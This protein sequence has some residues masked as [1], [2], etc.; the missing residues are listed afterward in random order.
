MLIGETMATENIKIGVEIVSNT[1]NETAAAK[2]LEAA[3]KSAAKAA[4]SVGGTAG[5]RAMA[6]KAGTGEGTAYG[7][8]RS[9]VGTGA[10]GRDFAK[11]AQGLGGLVHVYATFAANLFAV[12][13]AFTALRNAADTTNMVNGLDQLGAVSGRS[14]GTLSKRVVD[15]T[16]GMV[17]LR[18]A[19]TATAQA[20]SAGMSSANL[21]KLAE[22]AKNA[23]AV[24]GISMPDALSRLSRGITK[25]EPELLDELGV[26]VKVDK[27]TT[28]YARTLGKTVGSLTDFEKRT[29]FAVAV[30]AELDTK[31]GDIEGKTN[32]F[33]RLQASLENITQKGLEVVAKFITPLVDLLA[34]SPTALATALTAVGVALLKMAIP[35]LSNWKSNLLAQA[36]VASKIA[37]QMSTS[38]AEYQ[39]E[40]TIKHE[41]EIDKRMSVERNAMTK[42]LAAMQQG[43]SG[44]VKSGKLFNLIQGGVDTVEK[45]AQA[46]KL[47]DTQIASAT[48]RSAKLANT[49]AAESASYANKATALKATRDQLDAYIISLNNAKNTK[50]KLIEAE[51]K[52]DLGNIIRRR[53]LEKA[54]TEYRKLTLLGSVSQDTEHMGFMG[55]ITKLREGVAGKV[56]ENFIGP[57]PRALEGWAKWSTLVQGGISA[58]VT[59][60]GSFLSAFSNIT[61]YIGIAIGAYTMFDTWLSKANKE[62]DDFSNSIDRNKEVTEGLGRTIEALYKNK[63]MSIE[64]I[65]AVSNAY[66]DLADS[67]GASVEKAKQFSIKQGTWDTIKEGVKSLFKAD[68]GSNLAESISTQVGYAFNTAINSPEK[69]KFQESITELLGEVKSGSD[70]V[71]KIGSNQEKAKQLLEIFKQYSHEIANSASRMNEFTSSLEQAVKISKDLSNSFI[72]SD[73]I[74]KLGIQML[75]VAG[76]MQASMDK[77]LEQFKEL[78]AVVKDT[79]KIAL[80]GPEVGA[81]LIQ[82]SSGVEQLASKLANTDANILFYQNEMAKIS[83]LEYARDAKKRAKKDE[84]GAAVQHLQGVSAEQQDESKKYTAIF[85]KAQVEAAKKG[86]ELLSASLGMAFEK[87]ALTIEKAM[88]TGWSGRGAAIAELTVSNKEISIQEA[89]INAQIANTVALKELTLQFEV[90][91]LEDKLA[92]ESDK[93]KQAEISKQLGTARAAQSMVN[94]GITYKGVSQIIS[95]PEASE[96]TKRAAVSLSAYTANIAGSQAQKAQQEAQKVAN[97]ENA[98]VK[99]INE[100][101]A[102]YSLTTYNIEK[103]KLS[104]KQI[105]LQVLSQLLSGYT[106]EY[107]IKQSDNKLDQMALDN[108]KAR[109]EYQ[110]QLQILK[111]KTGTELQQADLKLAEDARRVEY[112][113]QTTLE[114]QAQTRLII[115]DTYLKEKNL[116]DITFAKEQ[117]SLQFKE[118]DIS[119]AK[120]M[121]IQRNAMWRITDEQAETEKRSLDRQALQNSYDMES[122]R[123][124]KEK[125]EKLADIQVKIDQTKPGGD[126]KLLEESKKATE[127]YYTAQGEQLDKVTGKKKASLELDQSMSDKMKGF[128]KIVEDSFGNMGDAL[129]EFARTGKFNFSNLI[130]SMIADLVRFELRAQMSALYKSMGGLSGMLN[131]LDNTFN[132]SAEAVAVANGTMP[133]LA[134]GGAYDNGIQAFAQGGAFTNSIVNSPTLF[135]FAKGTG[136]MGEAGPE[137]IMPLKRDAQG[138]LGVRTG[139]QPTTTVV[140]NNYGSEQATTQETTDSKGNRRIEVIIGEAVAKEIGRAN[141]PVNSGLK[142]NFQLQ[143]NLVRR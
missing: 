40:M 5:S 56:D 104:T 53:N 29:A 21:L 120:D 67:L 96:E 108:D 66:N 77:P 14:L 94:S 4:A 138:N 24:L 7:V 17:S 119:M 135:K 76:K 81:Q 126:T 103:N 99:A 55:A 20:T 106:T 100:D 85:E 2:G 125:A 43:V 9:A 89:Q 123:L 68:I 51:Q 72:P 47:L 64:G 136:M 83:D 142:A 140:V 139:N 118:Q 109:F 33:S 22:G 124:T 79:S 45:Q 62:L 114:R 25:I 44:G 93:N 132:P 102:A 116:R 12:T 92:R 82:M 3:Y 36:N 131:V 32:P 6:E 113:K 143:P 110:K 48:T 130:N 122:L 75:D 13:A 23:S 39:H 16:D 84:L 69:Q 26:F 46:Y 134:K 90:Q 58:A 50:E 49:N 34:S 127:A 37:Q 35:A 129:V 137:A 74:G 28:D 10:A 95:N 115:Q 11:Q 112:N 8:A 42:S 38:Y 80:F 1:K 52:E 59:S 91:S 128:S 98:R 73:N 65:T 111:G 60:I 78:N 41:Q 63:G 141:S 107:D 54:N 27:A 117:Q 31:F 57:P 18:E 86:S 19:M 97:K 71:S 133:V 87:A 121:L 88:A 61:A 105:E 30:L 70:I 15:V 101:I